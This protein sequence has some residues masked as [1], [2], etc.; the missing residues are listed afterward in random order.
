MKILYYLIVHYV[1]CFLV[2]FDID[3]MQWFKEISPNRFLNGI[4][5]VTFLCVI[6]TLPMV[7]LGSSRKR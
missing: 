2:M 4:L 7:A 5:C 1:I 6:F 3:V